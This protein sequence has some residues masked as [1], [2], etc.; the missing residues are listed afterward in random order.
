MSRWMNYAS[1]LL[2]S[3]DSIAKEHLHGDT[4]WCSMNF[5]D[6]I[7]WL[8]YL[9]SLYYYCH[10]LIPPQSRLLLKQKCDAGAARSKFPAVILPY[11]LS[12]LPRLSVANIKEGRYLLY[13]PLFR[14]MQCP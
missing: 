2:D 10:D 12:L 14:G 1:N 9:I 7:G 6:M 8:S 3:V 4:G 11:P 5:L 13:P